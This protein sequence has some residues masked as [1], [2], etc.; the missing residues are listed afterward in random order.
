[1]ATIKPETIS[2][3]CNVTFAAVATAFAALAV[4][5]LIQGAFLDAWFFSL[6]GGLF[7]IGGFLMHRGLT[8]EPRLRRD[9][10]WESK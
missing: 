2:L 7:I 3:I 8:P 4:Y 10:P 1:M 5:R 9:W 6:G